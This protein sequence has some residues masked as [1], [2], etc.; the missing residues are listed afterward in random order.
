[1]YTNYFAWEIDPVSYSKPDHIK[2]YTKYSG[3]RDTRHLLWH[4]SD[5]SIFKPTQQ[6]VL[7]TFMSE[8]GE[9]CTGLLEDFGAH[10]QDAPP[11]LHYMFRVHTP[12]RCTG[13][14]ISF[15]AF[16]DQRSVTIYTSDI[17]SICFTGNMCSAFFCGELEI[18]LDL[19]NSLINFP[20]L[21]EPDFDNGED[22]VNSD[23]WLCTVK[24]SVGVNV[25][26][27]DIFN[28]NIAN[29]EIRKK[30]GS[31]R[32]LSSNLV[33]IGAISIYLNEATKRLQNLSFPGKIKYQNREIR[34]LSGTRYF[35][36]R[37]DI[38]NLWAHLTT[39]N[40]TL[41]ETTSEIKEFNNLLSLVNLRIS[42]NSLLTNIVKWRYKDIE[43]AIK[44]ITPIA[45]EQLRKINTAVDIINVSNFH[46][47][48][49]WR[50][51]VFN[52]LKTGIRKQK[53][54]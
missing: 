22:Y 54:G 11:Y 16:G 17:E 2:L 4:N 48:V 28:A 1:M 51:Y 15:S 35:R 25:I 49:F 41:I 24:E 30:V 33:R 32:N 42:N 39:L 52:I 53:V 13:P 10:T 14:G 50:Q 12:V 36:F 29:V 47:N 37:S 18:A 31:L 3:R 46:K 26:L 44:A 34:Y 8:S 27:D 40:D 20:F 9:V 6:G 19:P 7:C 45:T 43:T 38:H 23:Y 21:L 5:N